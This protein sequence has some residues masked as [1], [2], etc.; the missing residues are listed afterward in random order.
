[1]AIG[2]TSLDEQQLARLR[3]VMRNV[4]DGALLLQYV[5]EWLS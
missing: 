5:C 4:R 2:K 1:M 3:A